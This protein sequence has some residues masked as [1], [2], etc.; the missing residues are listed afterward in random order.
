M[1]CPP[2]ATARFFIDRIMSETRMYD[3]IATHAR[4]HPDQEALIDDHSSRS[5]TYLELDRRV[6][7][8]AAYMKHRLGVL[9]G[10]RVATL[11]HN[12]T[13]ILE[14]QFACQRIGAIFVPLN[15]RLAVAELDD[16]LRDCG[17]V[18]LLHDSEFVGAAETLAARLPI[19]AM[20][21][22][23]RGEPC[24]YEQAIK[25]DVGLGDPHVSGL[26]DCWTLIYTSG[27]TGMPKGV[28]VT[29]RMVLFHAINYGFATG[30]TSDSHGLTFL[31]MFHTSGLNLAANPCLLAGGKVTVM[32]RFDPARA[33]ALMSRCSHVF[34]VP[35]NYLFMQQLPEFA[36]AD[37]SGLRSMGVGGAPMPMPLLSAYAEKGAGMQ[38]TFGMTETGP[39]V[40]ILGAHRTLD[41]QGSA[42][43]PV[44]HMEVKVMGE[45]GVEI[46]GGEIG[47]LWVRGP[48]ITPGYWNRPEETR[49][50]FVDGWFR[51]GDMVRCDEDG[52][53][54]V[55][56]RCKN[57]YI[58]GGENVYPAEV[59][60]V[61][62]RLPGVKEV[63]VVSQPDPKWGEVGHAAIVP[64]SGARLS[65][66]AI[67]AQCRERLAGYKV[68]RQ[69][70]LLDALPRNATGKV[71]RKTLLTRLSRGEGM[72]ENTVPV[73]PGLPGDRPDHSSILQDHSI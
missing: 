29:Y 3:W 61:I 40:T 34:G 39:T 22:H 33:L 16:I 35:A 32:R 63:A 70:S 23:E 8:L 1:H 59:E 11:A 14:V 43:L 56:D 41:K 15:V 47:E 31:P 12:S 6:Q 2:A 30:L 58:S 18:A 71:D 52:Y 26:S 17:A 50:S 46:T 42:G 53:Y 28:M 54:H 67:L 27:T 72:S 19:R 9:P 25:E 36:Q 62:E 20:L 10:E 38:Q 51:T 65:T 5:F 44:M 55:V 60:R 7:A 24:E 68:P 13:H 64:V 48:S 49:K 73:A 69:V 21:M 45:Q 66:E 37:L 57:M 4:S